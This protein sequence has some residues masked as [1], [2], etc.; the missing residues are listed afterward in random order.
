MRLVIFAVVAALI[1]GGYLYFFS[2]R[3]NQDNT[4]KVSAGIPRE[5]YC[6]MPVRRTVAGADRVFASYEECM[7]KSDLP[8][9]KDFSPE[10]RKVYEMLNMPQTQFGNGGHG[11][12]QR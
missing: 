7:Q 9:L 11:Q 1:A 2:E 4:P 3:D 8:L 10:Q 6:K 5:A 12:Q